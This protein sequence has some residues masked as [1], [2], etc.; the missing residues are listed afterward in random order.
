MAHFGSIK[1]ISG[2]IVQLLAV[3]CCCQFTLFDMIIIVV[4]GDVNL[5]N[6]II[7]QICVRQHQTASYISV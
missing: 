2:I 5:I 6:S 3:Q 7:V 4:D 1:C